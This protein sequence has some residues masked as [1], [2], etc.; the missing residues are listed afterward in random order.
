MNKA[1]EEPKWK[2][3]EKII[4]EIHRQ[5][6]PDAN[7]EHNIK[8]TGKSGNECQLDV[9]VSRNVGPY[10]ILIV[11]ECKDEADRVDVGE[12]REFADTLLDVEAQLGILISASGFTSGA[13]KRAAIQKNLLLHTYREAE[14]TDWDDLIGRDAG[15]VIMRFRS[16]KEAHISV[17]TNPELFGDIP[18][19]TK[20]LMQATTGGEGVMEITPEVIFWNWWEQIR[21]Q[22]LRLG[23][24]EIS[25]EG[26]ETNFFIENGGLISPV[27]RFIM[28]GE[29]I[30]EKYIVNL[31]MG[32]G[33]ILEDI[34]TGDPL[35]GELVSSSID[36]NRVFDGQ[37]GIKMNQEEY[38]SLT[39]SEATSHLIAFIDP[40]DVKETLQVSFILTRPEN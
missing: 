8:I 35:Y 4:A 19:D 31:S 36:W 34:K 20:F 17:A 9:I 23:T 16:E 11:I 38:D 33:K 1:S 2:K 3:F 32:E 39:T 15:L 40:R 5:I 27:H 21:Q 14:N 30:A 22:P 26:D 7:V 10:P 25:I 37:V 6:I 18:L 24:F 29:L 13:V 12:V 28:T